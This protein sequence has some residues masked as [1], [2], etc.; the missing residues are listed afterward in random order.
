MCIRDRRPQTGDKGIRLQDVAD[1]K[2]D[3]ADF[4][5][6][7]SDDELCTIVRGEGMNSPRVTRGTAGAIGGVS[8]ALQHYGLCLLYTSRCV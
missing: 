2:V 8:D 4:V 7:F 3:M 1:G 6:Q 5:A